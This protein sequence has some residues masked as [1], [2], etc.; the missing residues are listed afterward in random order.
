MM[1]IIISIFAFLF[2]LSSCT[3]RDITINQTHANEIVEDN[4][5]PPF[6]GVSTLQIQNFINK[7]F[8][9]LRGRAPIQTEMD[10]AILLLEGNDLSEEAKDALLNFLI[11]DVDYYLRFW[12]KYSSDLLEGTTREAVAG[13]V[14]QYQIA[15]DQSIQQG[16]EIA[17]AFFEIELGKMQALLD[18]LPEYAQGEIDII[19]YIARMINNAIYDEINMGSENFTIACFENL[20][21]RTPT[22]EELEAS[23][24]MINGFSTQVLFQDGNSKDDLV[25]IFTT[26]PEF[27][28]GLVFDIYRQLLFRDPNS[29][30]MT[31][32]TQ[33]LI[34]TQDYQGLQKMVMKTEEYAGF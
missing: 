13:Q 29:P 12:D 34:E 17:I 19:E 21:K 30:E 23:R 20:F 32:A 31:V 27:Y 10:Q 5:A 6:N 9:D 16:D 14:F 28:Q 22:V 7:A 18:A 8:I 11:A 1:R 26:V 25:E 2:I 15:L 3:K 24:L 4:T 33:M